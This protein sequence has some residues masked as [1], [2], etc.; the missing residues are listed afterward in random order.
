MAPPAWLRRLSGMAPPPP[1]PLPP[2]APGHP[3][4]EGLRHG[5]QV[6]KDE[7]LR[8]V[9][10]RE[11]FFLTVLLPRRNTWRNHFRALLS[12]VNNPGVA[13]PLALNAVTYIATFVTCASQPEDSTLCSGGP[14]KDNDV[15]SSFGFESYVPALINSFT[16]LMLAFYANTSL[17]LYMA[18]YHA[19]CDLKAAVIDVCALAN[20]TICASNQG[21]LFEMWRVANLLHICTYVLADKVMR[22]FVRAC[23]PSLRVIR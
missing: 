9:R 5:A 20:G 10:D 6:D 4:R 8:A 7:R 23:N 19:C 12:R 2:P 1:P 13:L 16:V 21:L 11:R 15:V 17:S 22:R 18:A 3:V 14:L